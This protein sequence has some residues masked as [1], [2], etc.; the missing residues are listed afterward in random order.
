MKKKL[1][2]LF[3]LLLFLV[4]S[5]IGCSSNSEEPSQTDSSESK[6]EETS[7]AVDESLTGTDLLNSLN[8]GQPESL[9]MTS[10]TSGIYGTDTTMTTM[11]QNGNSRME[12]DIPDVGKQIII[13]NASEGLTYQYIEGQ[14]T[15]MMFSDT[16]LSSESDLSSEFETEE[17]TSSF[18][19]LTDN[20]TG[21]FTARVEELNGEKVIYIETTEDSGDGVMV[22]KMWFS[23]QYGV[24]LKS[25]IYSSEELIASTEVTEISSEKLDNNLFEK[26]SGIEF[27]DFA[28]MDFS[29][30]GDLYDVE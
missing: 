9:S 17:M 15:G 19:D 14:T 7:A 8:I 20:L 3:V 21:D 4:L 26:P 28:S 27:T 24:P 2:P 1:F 12:M 5:L 11:I 10:V 29:D 16:E 13:Y 22:V 23:T 18:S 6:S 25:E 30:F